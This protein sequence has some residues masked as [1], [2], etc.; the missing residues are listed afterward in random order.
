MMK[1]LK[2]MIAFAV[3]M[4]PVVYANDN[5]KTPAEQANEVIAQQTVERIDAF[6]NQ[7]I[8]KDPQKLQTFLNRQR[9]IVMEQQQR[10]NQQKERT[11]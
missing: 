10:A 9:Q 7:Q 8:Q 5:Q 6:N 4:A 2:K 3:V 11:N 1:N